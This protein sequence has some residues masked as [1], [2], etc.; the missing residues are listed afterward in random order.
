MIG[1]PLK[2]V[3]TG[4]SLQPSAATWNAFVAA[5]QAHLQKRLGATRPS[6]SANGQALAIVQNT[7]SDVSRFGI[8]SVTGSML[9]PTDPNALPD[10]Q[11]MVALQCGTPQAG[12]PFVITLEPIAAGGV[13]MAVVAGVVQCQVNVNSVGDQFAALDSSGILQSG[14]SGPAQILWKA[15]GTGSQ[16]AIVN[17]GNPSAASVM[18]CRVVAAATGA[19]YT[20]IEQ[21]ANG[22]GFV[23][24]PSASNITATNMAE[25]TVGPGGAVDANT[26]VL[27]C[28]FGGNYV[29]DHPV[30]A[31]YLG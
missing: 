11:Q 5:A 10:F 13:G 19:Q 12:T 23:D 31:K 29:F 28:N 18:L 2:T 9:D 30:Y 17:L 3:T 27:V 8:L 16:W 15:S 6:I 20:V 22:A 24:K 25:A 26:R 14:A 4:Q 1:D 21:V 7:G